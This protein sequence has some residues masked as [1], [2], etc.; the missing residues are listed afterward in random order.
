MNLDSTIRE[1]LSEQLEIDHLDLRDDT[2]GHLHH[3]TYEGGAHISAVIVSSNFT[4]RSLI[5]RHKLVYSALGTM[6]KNEIHAF[7]MKTYTPEEWSQ[8]NKA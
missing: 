8:Q 3:K 5:E 6:L 1:K 4:D 7:S 2:G